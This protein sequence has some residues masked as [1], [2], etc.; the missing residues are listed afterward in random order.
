[1]RRKLIIIAIALL[2][3]A[4]IAGARDPQWGYKT[5]S[6]QTGDALIYTGAGWFKGIMA[7]TDGTYS[8]SV[9]IYD[10]VTAVTGSTAIIPVWTVTTS[11]SDK[12]QAVF[13]PFD[14]YFQ[15]G[16][17]VDIEMTGGTIRYVIYYKEE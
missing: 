16:V 10:A 15:T 9:S 5:S 12:A 8:A 14:V 1:M 13:L 2:L 4:A 7:V 11:S 17:V 3:V 6:Q